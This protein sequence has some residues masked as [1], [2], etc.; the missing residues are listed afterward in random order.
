MP[1]R[2]SAV[3]RILTALLLASLAITAVLGWQ[4]KTK[5]DRIALLSERND[6][7]NGLVDMLNKANHQLAT[8][9]Q[10]VADR[11]RRTLTLVSQAESDKRR[12]AAELESRNADLRRALRNQPDWAE[13]PV[14]G[15]IADNVNVALDRLRDT[16][17]GGDYQL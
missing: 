17:S 9:L 11:H 4:V 6:R 14:P 10:D 8:Q 7:L 13:T 2:E 1:I 16:A 12:M 5:A 15:P 3:T